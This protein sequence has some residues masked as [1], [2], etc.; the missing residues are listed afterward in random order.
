MIRAKGCITHRDIEG[1]NEA[2]DTA[3][4]IIG[5]LQGCLDHE[6]GGS[7]AANLDSL[8]EYMQR[9]LFRANVDSD[10]KAIDEVIDLVRT[11]KDA[12]DAIDE[13]APDRAAGAVLMTSARTGVSLVAPALVERVVRAVQR[14][15]PDALRAVDVD[16]RHLVAALVAIPGP[17]ATGVLTELADLYRDLRVQCE[18][19][20]H[21]SAA[22]MGEHRRTQVGLSVY[23]SSG[24]TSL[25]A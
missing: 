4:G 21:P 25:K 17:N 24:A 10:M 2:L 6:R 1:R 13:K 12:W 3:L 22:L 7:L 9:R 14:F 11:L 23:R 5:A 8:Y 18:T 20:T 19:R 15:D 16:V